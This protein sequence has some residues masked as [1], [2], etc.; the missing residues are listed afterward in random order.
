MNEKLIQIALSGQFKYFL[1]NGR[2]VSVKVLKYVHVCS[3]FD[4]RFQTSLYNN[5]FKY[6]IVGP[7]KVHVHIGRKTVY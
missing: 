5:G 2:M 3:M 4:K 6:F 7:C 1:A